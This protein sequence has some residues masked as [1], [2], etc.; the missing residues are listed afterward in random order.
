MSAPTLPRKVPVT[1]LLV[2]AYVATWAVGRYEGIDADSVFR[3]F[4]VVAVFT[5]ARRLDERAP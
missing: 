1:V 4:V 3:V 2:V 5:V